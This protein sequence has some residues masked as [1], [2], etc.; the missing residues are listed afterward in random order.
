MHFS[1]FTLSSCSFFRAGSF[2]NAI[3]A[4]KALS[5]DLYDTIFIATLS[6]AIISL[7]SLPISRYIIKK[8]C[9]FL[10]FIIGLFWLALV[11]GS[12][13]AI[14]I[15]RMI[16]KII[17]IPY[18]KEFGLLIRDSRYLIVLGHS[19]M[20]LPYGVF[21]SSI[22]LTSLSKSLEEIT[23]LEGYTPIKRFVY[24]ILPFSKKT[25]IMV[26]GISFM[27]SLGE[28]SLANLLVPP[29]HTTITL[30]IFSL[31]HSGTRSDV[32]SYSLFIIFIIFFVLMCMKILHRQSK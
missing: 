20:F 14:G 30:R 21:I 15:L 26:F 8:R 28:L 32:A 11:P 27:L 29:G 23:A 2:A 6:A 5:N 12:I 22:A 1:L 17:E 18:T 16:Q 3:K 9:F 19:L 7:L 4:Y 13:T 25:I 24:L 31:L 10:P